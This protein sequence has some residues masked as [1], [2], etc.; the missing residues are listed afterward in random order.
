[1]TMKIVPEKKHFYHCDHDNF[2]IKKLIKHKISKWSVNV[3]HFY[4]YNFHGYGKKP[5]HC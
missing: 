2:N 1:M 3:G 5:K 4:F